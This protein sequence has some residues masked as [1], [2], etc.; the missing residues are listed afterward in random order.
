MAESVPDA[1]ETAKASSTSPTAIE[2]KSVADA[3]AS[4]PAV[5]SSAERKSVRL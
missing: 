2:K 4:Q 1:S 5:A 3:Y